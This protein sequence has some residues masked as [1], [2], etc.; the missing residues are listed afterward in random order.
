MH[1]ELCHV[2]L[3]FGNSF[4][5]VFLAQWM[6]QDGWTAWSAPYPDLNPIDFYLGGRLWSTV[7]S[8]EFC[9]MWDL[10]Q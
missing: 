4:N 9:D 1:D 8:V 3:H 6:I 7:Y 10:Q 5:S 2:S